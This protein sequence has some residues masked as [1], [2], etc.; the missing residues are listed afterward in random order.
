MKLTLNTDKMI[1][2]FKPQDS[3][4]N[5]HPNEIFM[6]LSVLLSE[7][8][9]KLADVAFDEHKL[10]QKYVHMMFESIIDAINGLN[11]HEPTKVDDLITA[12]FYHESEEDQ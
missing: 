9:I 7:S 8:I 10:K 6:E 3:D 1:A 4:K 5:K 11:D 2:K 12:I